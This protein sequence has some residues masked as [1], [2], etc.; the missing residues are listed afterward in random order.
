M[1]RFMDQHAMGSMTPE[2]LRQFQKQPRDELDVLHQEI[3]Y[4]EK[5]N[6]VFCILDAPNKEAVEKH[7]Q[8]AGVKPE[9][10]IEVKSSKD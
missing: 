5:E 3:L 8:K 10:V 4:N 7:H 6:K 1:P 9:W 2:M